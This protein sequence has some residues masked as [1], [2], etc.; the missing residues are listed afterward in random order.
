MSLWQRSQVQKCCHNKDR[1]ITQLDRQMAIEV[2]Q[3]Y[4]ESCEERAEA[5]DVFYA[6]LD[7]DAPTMTEHFRE[8]SES[9]FLF[10]FTFDHQLDDGSYVVDRVLE[11][12]PLLSAGEHRYL[13]QMR[14]TAMMPYEVTACGPVHPWSCAGWVRRKRSKCARGRLPRRCNG[15]ICW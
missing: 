13:E 6:G 5:R 3:R 1:T 11:A 4:V 15:G 8:T 9:A 10:W 12:N 7:L 14:T 2:I